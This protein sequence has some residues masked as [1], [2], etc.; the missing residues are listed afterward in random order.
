[1]KKLLTTMAALLLFTFVSA[2]GAYAQGPF[3]TVG[4]WTFFVKINGAP[5]CQCI[6]LG[7]LKADGT[8]D[9]PGNDNFTG[10]GF[11]LWKQV[12]N[13]DVKFVITQ[14][15]MN[16]D[17]TAAGVYVIKGSMTLNSAGDAGSGTSTFQLLGNDGK[18]IVSGTATFIA[19]KLK[20]D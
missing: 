19:T 16:D 18:A 20:L 10:N 6:Q 9:A 14:N 7:N 15:A 2:H 8:I 5:P 1:M 17:G 4:T 12:G 3:T 11:G 13:G